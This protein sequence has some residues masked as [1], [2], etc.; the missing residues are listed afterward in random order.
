MPTPT[1]EQLAIFTQATEHPSTALVIEALAGTG[2]T[3][4]ILQLCPQLRGQ[5][6]LLAYNKS[7]QQELL[8]RT[9]ATLKF[10]T[11]ISTVHAFGLGTLKRNGFHKAKVD[12]GKLHFLF[13]NILDTKPSFAGHFND[14]RAGASTIVNLASYAKTSGF[15]VSAIPSIGPRPSFPSSESFSD[16]TNLILHYGLDEELEEHGIP[17]DA[18]V[19][20]ARK[21]LSES[22]RSEGMIDFDDMI[23]LPLLM[24]MTVPTFAH[25]IIDEAQ[26]ISATRAELAARAAVGGRLIA[27]GDRHQ[28]IYGFTGADNQ[29][30]NNLIA[31][32]AA[33]TL[34]LTICWRCDADVITEAQRYVPA[35]Q[36]KPNASLGSV[37]E[38]TIDQFLGDIPPLGSA[39][40]CRLNRP[41]VAV[42]L[43]L[44]RKG[45]PAKIEGRDLGK[46]I[47][48]HIQKAQPLYATTA[49]DDLIIAVENYRDMETGALLRKKKMSAAASLQDEV[50]CA[51]LLIERS[52]ETGGTRYSELEALI[53]TIFGDDIQGSRLVTLSSVHKAKGREWPTVYILGRDDYMPFWMAKQE[54]EV[55]QE[56]N[57]IYVAVTRAEHHLVSITGVKSWL[58]ARG[59]SN[60]DNN[61]I[62][63]GVR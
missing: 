36:P 51:V 17:I 25:V 59:R 34:P 58:D 63:G 52:I 54:W 22:V 55:E 53:N 14:R 38:L 20:M 7:I 32:H 48:K 9:P 15:D 27:V 61:A 23:Y 4:T 6:L 24:D 28:A 8:K 39:I 43:E 45:I 16:W 49:L 5:I 3:T 30:M 10:Q 2:K 44:I 57:L 33:H 56:H 29:A 46:S 50:D 19:E 12:G 31:R 60:D 37:S 1:P 47:T 41:N 11:S 62:L 13:R 35:I 18:A 26:D 40:L 42:A 21:L